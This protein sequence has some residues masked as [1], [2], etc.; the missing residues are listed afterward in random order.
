MEPSGEHL[1]MPNVKDSWVLTPEGREIDRYLLTAEKRPD[2]RHI[3]NKMHFAIR[4][5]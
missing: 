3:Q 4:L 1:W 2:R 5:L